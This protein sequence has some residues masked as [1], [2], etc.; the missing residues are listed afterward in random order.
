MPGAG[1]VEGRRGERAHRG[2]QRTRVGCGGGKEDGLA[3]SGLVQ[4][5]LRAAAMGHTPS[6]TRRRSS[7]HL[8]SSPSART[9][10]RSRPSWLRREETACTPTP[11]VS[12]PLWSAHQR[13]C[14]VINGTPTCAGA[15]SGHRHTVPVVMLA[16]AARPSCPTLTASSPV[17]SQRPPHLALHHEHEGHVSCPLFCPLF[18]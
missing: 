11:A 18:K 10:S 1:G 15:V 2:W 9:S 13:P 5:L 8:S 16:A 4:L 14:I 6:L 17:A 12:F 3:S 7:T